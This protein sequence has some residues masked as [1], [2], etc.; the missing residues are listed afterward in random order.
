M[1]AAGSLITIQWGVKAVEHLQ[2]GDSIVTA[3]G[4]MLPIQWIGYRQ[5]NCRQ[6]PHPERVW[7]IRIDAHAFGEG[8]PERPLMLSPDHSVFVEDVLIPIKFLINETTI[9]QIRVESIMYYHIELPR[10]DI[11]LAE[12][13]PVESYLETGGRTAFTNAGEITELHPNFVLDENNVGRSGG[14]S[15]APRCSAME[16]SLLGRKQN[17]TSKL[18]CSACLNLPRLGCFDRPFEEA[19]AQMQA[20]V[21]VECGWPGSPRPAAGPRDDI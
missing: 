21:G 13:L 8:R 19:G 4:S 17:C 3:S 6:H 20:A 7:P 14:H 18:V 1:F 11:L 16:I 10:H 5:V 9:K 12:G 15:R 2:V